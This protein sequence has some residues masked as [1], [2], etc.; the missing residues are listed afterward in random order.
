MFSKVLGVV[1]SFLG[2]SAFAKDENGKSI[3]LSTQQE[4]LKQKYG[5]KFLDAF[6][7]DL[8]EFEKEGASA[9]SAVTSEVTASLEAERD[10]YASELEAARAKLKALENKEA[11]FNAAIKAKDE[12]IDALSRNEENAEGVAVDSLASKPVSKFKPDM[13]LM[14]NRYIEA[15]FKGAAYSGNDTIDTTELQKEFGK[16]VSAERMQILMDLLGET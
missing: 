8:A 3:L 7:K 9:E 6:L 11:Q 10:K 4:Q 14:H 5:E 2:I 13:S 1:L 16:Y 15:A 12:Q